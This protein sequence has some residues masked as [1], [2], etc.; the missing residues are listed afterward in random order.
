MSRN[1]RMPATKLICGTFLKCCYIKVLKIDFTECSSSPQSSLFTT[2]I[3]HWNWA[4]ETYIFIYFTV[5]Y[6]FIISDLTDQYILSIEHRSWHV[7]G[8]Q[9]TFVERNMC[10]IVCCSHYLFSLWEAVEHSDWV[11][12]RSQWL[13]RRPA[14][15]FH[16][17]R[18]FAHHWWH[19]GQMTWPL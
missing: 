12:A 4:W 18:N 11:L 9:E 2:E 7:V 5:H 13:G 3:Y 17:S 19:F 10:N 14:E 8:S 6:G 16:L 1:N 15:A